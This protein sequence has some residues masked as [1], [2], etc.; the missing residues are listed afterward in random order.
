[1]L[2]TLFLKVGDV[3]FPARLRYVA[4]SSGRSGLPADAGSLTRGR[5][6]HRP[7]STNGSI[8]VKRGPEVSF[9]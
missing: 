2:V 8:L 7:N 1:M 3:Y 9:S 6:R 5:Q 4:L